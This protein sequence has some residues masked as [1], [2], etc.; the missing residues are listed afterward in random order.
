MSSVDD[1]IVQMTF[2]NKQ[3]EDGAKTTLGTID[4]LKTALK[5]TGAAAGLGDVEKVASSMSLDHIGNAV[6]VIKGKFSTLGL[7]GITTLTNLANKAVDAGLRIVKSLTIAPITAGLKS[8]SDS[9]DA[10]QTILANTQAQGTTLKDVTA[11]LKELQKYANQTVY[12]FADMTKNIGTFTAAGV[13]LK[14]STSSIKGIANLAAMSGASATQASTAM[15]QLSQAISSGTVRLQDWKSV[16]NASIGGATFK[17]SLIE[18]AQ[19]M[20]TLGKNAVTTTGKMKTL[21]VNGVSFRDSLAPKKG[22][23]KGEGAAPAWLTSDVLTKTLE[24]LTGDMTD[25][26]LAA[27]GFTK[28]QIKSMQALAKTALGAATNIKTIPQGMQALKEEVA[29]A[30]G[31]VFKAIFGDIKQ[32]TKL[33]TNVHNVLENIFTGPVKRIARVLE[34]WGKKGGRIALIDGLSAGVHDLTRL[35]KAAREAWAGVFPKASSDM[36][37]KITQNIQHFMK[38]IRIGTDSYRNLRRTFQGLFAILDIVWQVFKGVTKSLFSFFSLVTGNTG[39]FLHFTS[40]V[41]RFFIKLDRYL[42][43]GDKIGA[44]F[45]GF[46]DARNLVLKPLAEAIGL[47]GDAIAFL[48]H[49]D[50]SGFG[51]TMIKAFQALL[52]LGDAV[53]KR[54]DNLSNIFS[55]VADF[56]RNTGIAAFAPIVKLF[57]ILSLK[58]DQFKDKVSG[59][60]APKIKMP[61]FG[62]RG[63]NLKGLVKDNVDLNKGLERTGVILGDIHAAIKPVADAFSKFF[64]I[65]GDKLAQ[66]VKGFTFQDATALI[67]TGFFIMAYRTV[68]NFIKVVQK[69]FEGYDKLISGITGVFTQLTD[70]LK[71]MQQQVKANIIKTIAI[72]IALLAAAVWVLSTIDVGNLGIA[73]GAITALFTELIVTMH[74]FNKVGEM[75]NKDMLSVAAS[76]LILSA[77]LLIL[78]VAVKILG[79]MNLKEIGTGLTAVGGLLGALLLFTKMAKMDKAGK[80]TGAGL[81]LLAGAIA[82]LALSVAVFGKMDRKTLEQGLVTLALIAIGIV[83]FSNGMN[84]ISGE[85]KQSAIAILILSAALIVLAIAMKMFVSMN[86]VKL[87]VA[88]AIVVIAISALADALLLMDAALPGATALITAAGAIL[89][90][91][92]ALKS[93]SKLSWGG[94]AKAIIGLVAVLAVLGLA[95][96]AMVVFAPELALIG[97]IFALFGAA[98]FLAGTGVLAFATGLTMLAAL[99]P[100]A[101]AAISYA[102]SSFAA[103]LPLIAQQFGLAIVAFAKVIGESKDI[104]IPALRN[105]IGMLI[106]SLTQLLP[107]IE[108]FISKLLE[109]LINIVKTFIPQYVMMGVDIILALIQGM[110]DRLPEIMKAVAELIG[111]FFV[112]LGAMRNA[113]IAAGVKLITDFLDGVTKNV[114]K[115]ANSVVTLITTFITAVG[116]GATRIA[117]AGVKLLTDFLDAMTAA[118]KTIT[119]HVKTLITTIITSIGALLS[120]IVTAGG[121]FVKDFMLGVANEIVSVVNAAGDVLVNF[122]NG[123]AEAIRTHSGEIRAAGGNIAGAIMDGFSGGLA[124]KAG[125]VLK[126]IGG[127]F[128]KVVSVPAKV[129]DSH[130]PSKVFIKLGKSVTDGFA[131]GIKGGQD[132]IIKSFSDMSANIKSALADQRD[133]IAKDNAKLAALRQNR[134]KI[135]KNITRQEAKIANLQGQKKP[136]AQA[137]ANAKNALSDMQDQQK[138][139][140][141]AITAGT[142]A[143][144]ADQRRRET[145]LAGQKALTKQ[146]TAGKQKLVDLANQYDDVTQKLEDASKAL[147]DAVKARDDF[148]ASITSKFSDAPD[149]MIDGYA[150]SPEE[151]AAAIDRK[152]AATNAFADSLQQLRDRGLDDASYQRLLDQ[153]LEAQPFVDNLVAGGDAAISSVNAS[154]AALAAAAARLGQ[155]TSTALYQAGV[156]SAQGLVDGLVSQ[157]AD[158]E[159]QMT[160]LAGAIVTAIKTALKIKSPSQI[161]YEIGAFSVQGLAKGFDNTSKVAEQSA[162]DV[163]DA[164]VN[165]MRTS[166][167]N[168]ADYMAAEVDFTPVIAPVLD[169]ENIRT[170]AGKLQDM[171]AIQP[172]S[173]ASTYAQAN[174][175]SAAAT[176]ATDAAGATT[177]ASAPTLVFEQHNTSPE[178]LSTSEIYRNTRNQLSQA[179]SVLN[180]I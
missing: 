43:E 13:D 129:L 21:M 1:R 57:E 114:K 4:K 34:N 112:G 20:G 24:H 137:I 19:A 46:T 84:A 101:V 26:Q 31:S 2:N 136:N 139:N 8:Y 158:I 51:D 167:E 50:F 121:Q 134:S 130:S 27:E 100:P 58:L 115:I 152:T 140:T 117:A 143:L 39:S 118:T 18:T 30:W 61:D 44:F 36:L 180:L 174:Q 166:M 56:L 41:A 144:A 96:A 148:A 67:N 22:N 79:S 138:A 173:T 6:D 32:A 86:P 54:F 77:A 102:V 164:T 93:L 163:G 10:T 170:G 91:S 156:N 149:F 45:K 132:D 85:I 124:S 142:S 135:A 133:I 25:A 73:L 111:A 179:R 171:M 33:F 107:N 105:M 120:D 80:E 49:G 81:L 103:M 52:G 12:S 15:Y 76:I 3:F 116:S 172:I 59:L 40:E 108:A 82:L 92:I 48:I 178:A 168:I 74:F 37:L 23:K 113:I 109:S 14:T 119:S 106:D 98:L 35:F 38:Q 63:N 165:A 70:N 53:G 94:L 69:G 17:K 153:G 62:G 147:D 71:T 11:T 128:G 9:I 42:K 123:L 47:V 89:I 176:T 104:L 99:G 5:F 83:A 127:F 131:I 87:G 75:G 60:K 159:T 146:A 151:Y 122:L 88:M 155:Q 177:P 55:K 78:A 169:L 28:A 126:G 16:E 97:G 64:S 145:I 68:N 65:V 95:V 175:I 160:T 125:G 66:F 157:Q 162:T 154:T 141:R 110:R 7:I 90:L 29:T 150:A 72:S 161:F